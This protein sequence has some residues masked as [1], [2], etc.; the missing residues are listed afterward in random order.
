MDTDKQNNAPEDVLEIAHL[1]SSNNKPELEN[2]SRCGCFSCMRIYDPKLITWYIFDDNPI[3]R[4]GTAVCPFCG[5]DSV[6]GESAD[7]PLSMEF[8]EEMAGRWFGFF[9]AFRQ[10]TS[11]KGGKS[12]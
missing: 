11:Q 3:D 5:V 1:H 12:E 6:L 7:Y 2:S 9:S 4:L 8:L 10:Q